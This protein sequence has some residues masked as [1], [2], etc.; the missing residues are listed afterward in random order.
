MTPY[1]STGWFRWMIAGA[2]SLVM[3]FGF[4]LI[5][6]HFYSHLA[7]TMEGDL[8]RGVRSLFTFLSPPKETRFFPE[9][10]LPETYDEWYSKALLAMGEQPLWETRAR[11]AYRLIFLPASADHVSIRIEAFGE[12]M[13]LHIKTLRR[14]P[15]RTEPADTRT[16]SEVIDAT[17]ANAQTTERAFS[18][19][20]VQWSQVQ[21][22]ISS[23]G[24]WTLPSTD[25]DFGRGGGRWV[26]EGFQGGRYHVVDRWSPN[27]GPN[28]SFHRACDALLRLAGLPGIKT[29]LIQ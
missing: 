15:P 10:A 18:V 28:T 11:S 23:S 26:L 1:D 2:V 16:A 19:S 6:G 5:L 3:A 9:G 22:L 7:R 17:L 27:H 24:F 25:T 13:V 8:A 29:T 14:A 4:L 21:A 20:S 12:A